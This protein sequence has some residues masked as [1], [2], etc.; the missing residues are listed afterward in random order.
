MKKISV[1]LVS[2]CLLLAAVPAFAD[3]LPVYFQRSDLTHPEETVQWVD[4]SPFAGM[5]EEDLLQV[6]FLGIRQGDCI[7]I[8]YRGRRMLIDGGESFRF[9]AVRAYLK[10]KG[11]EHFDWFLLT[12]AHD[13]HIGL[14]RTLVLKGYGPDIQYS[15]YDPDESYTEWKPYVERLQKFGVEMV[16]LQTGDVIDIEDDVTMKIYRWD[17]KSA[18]LMNGHS[19]VTMVQFG[20]ARILLTGDIDG[21]TQNWLLENWAPEEFKCDIMK[22]PHHGNNLLQTAFADATAP[23]LMIITNPKSY[24]KT[25]N[26]QLAKRHIPRLHIPSTVHC[27]TDGKIWYVWLEKMPAYN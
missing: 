26:S 15:P 2:L 20:D 12:H 11:I 23:S 18:A 25:L 6:D 21:D 24:T 19:I 17:R 7:I 3:G 22:A 1:L 8:S 10:A 5:N 14:P 13:D 27:Q 16:K 4:E 9:D